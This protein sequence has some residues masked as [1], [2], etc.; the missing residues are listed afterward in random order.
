MHRQIS[1]SSSLHSS[2]FVHG[3]TDPRVTYSDPKVTYSDPNMTH[4]DP[5]RTS[6]CL[7]WPS[8]GHLLSKIK[9]AVVVVAGGDQL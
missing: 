6:T 1:P 8:P 7:T 4:S 9:L 2:S 5:L 3:D